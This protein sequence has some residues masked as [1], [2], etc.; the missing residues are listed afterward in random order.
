MEQSDHLFTFRDIW[1]ENDKQIPIDPTRRYVPEFFWNDLGDRFLKTF[2]N[3]REMQANVGWVIQKLKYLKPETVLEIGCSFGRLAPF[4]IQGEACK[5]YV[6]ID[7]A[8]SQ[9]ASSNTY[10]KID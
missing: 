1:D 2:R 3:E 8:Q 5:E 10:L 4:L 6:G 7:I 9:I